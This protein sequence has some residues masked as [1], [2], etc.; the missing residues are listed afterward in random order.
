MIRHL[1]AEPANPARVV[2]LG[3]SGFL[4]RH[5]I[6]HLHGLGIEAVGL[7]SAHVDLCAAGAADRLAALLRKDDAVVFAS[8]LTP[9]KG[10]DI[11]TAMRNLAMGE[12]V[13]AALQQVPCAHVVY[14]SSD[15]VYA[16]SESLV[17]EESRCEPSTL[18]GLGHF[19]RE[20]M[21]RV[22]AEACGVPW[23]IVR[24]TLVYGA[25]DSHNSYGPNRFA[26]QARDGGPIKLFGNGEEKRDHIH[27][28][29][30][31]RLL[32]LCLRHRSSG[33]LNLAT[34][35]SDSFLE[36]A[37]V[38]V[39]LSPRPVSIAR[40]PRGGPVTHRHFD[41]SALARAFPAFAFTPLRAGVA[42]EYFGAPEPLAA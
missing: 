13:S 4:G 5:L 26:R 28:G 41:I 35:V 2:V 36:V 16:D 11:R 20:R 32:G 15:A 12:Q 42:A 31:A 38:C 8:C 7:S 34:G 30:A 40:Q 33:I 23:L 27:V 19:T 18:Y 9:D 22:T 3:G 6:A 39:A 1:H 24:P 14:V 29:D 17:R 25:D 10:K 21:V 37:E